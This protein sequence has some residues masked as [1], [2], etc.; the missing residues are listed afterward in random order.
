LIDDQNTEKIEIRM[1]NGDV[2]EVR[3]AEMKKVFESLIES[4]SQ[5]IICAHRLNGYFHQK[6][7]VVYIRKSEISS[8][9]FYE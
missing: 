9:E 2:Y 8:I 7:S 1:N 4:G 3:K 5:I 6:C